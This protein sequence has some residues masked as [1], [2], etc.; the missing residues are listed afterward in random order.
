S[1]ELP[2]FSYIEPFWG[3]GYG[4]PTGDDFIGLQGNDYHSPAW[5]GPAEF[6]LNEMYNALRSSTYWDE[7]LFVITFDEHGGTW[8]HIPPLQTVKPDAYPGARPFHF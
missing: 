1:D 2:D 5:V 3:G 6:D 7:M 4:L 8:D